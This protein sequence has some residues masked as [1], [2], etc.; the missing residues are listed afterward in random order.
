MSTVMLRKL[1]KQSFNT[2]KLHEISNY[3]TDLLCAGR[4]VQN[5]GILQLRIKM[6]GTAARISNTNQ[7]KREKKM[8]VIRDLEV[9]AISLS[10]RYFLIFE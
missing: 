10:W 1:L 6:R 8:K 9:T 2:E 7:E 3:T 5:P 4:M